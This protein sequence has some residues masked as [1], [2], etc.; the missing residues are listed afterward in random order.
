MATILKR[1]RYS[2]ELIKTEKPAVFSRIQMDLNKRQDFDEWVSASQLRNYMMQDPLL[3]FLNLYGEKCGFIPDDQRPEYIDSFNINKYIMEQGHRFESAVLQSIKTQF[4]NDFLVITEKDHEDATSVEKYAATVAA[5]NQRAAAIIIHGVLHGKT[6]KT[7]GVVDLMIQESFLHKLFPTFPVSVNDRYVVIDIKFTTLKL[8]AKGGYLLNEGSIPAYK[9]QIW[10]YHQLLEEIQ[11]LQY[12]ISEKYTNHF[13]YVLG[14][15]CSLGGKK[16]KTDFANSISTAETTRDAERIEENDMDNAP[17]CFDMLGIIDYS[18]KDAEYATLAQNAIDWLRRLKSIRSTM[19]TNPRKI[20]DNPTHP[21]NPL[22]TGPA[23]MIELYP[24]MSNTMDIPWHYAKKDI[25]KQVSE[26]TCLWNMG[27]KRRNELVA[28]GITQ[29]VDLTVK[30]LAAEFKSV[31]RSNAPNFKYNILKRILQINSADAKNQKIDM[32]NITSESAQRWKVPEL[33]EF[34][35]DFETVSDI[36]DS[37]EN[38]PQAGGTPMIYMIGC[39]Y[40]DPFTHKWIFRNFIANRLQYADEYIIVSHWLNYMTEVCKELN[41]IGISPRIYHWSF[42]ERSFLNSA[43]GR[44]ETLAP[45]I[46]NYVNLAKAV[47]GLNFIDLH[48]IFLDNCI[49]VKGAFNFRLKNI[50]TAMFNHGFIQTNWGNSTVDGIGASIC[51]YRCNDL[52]IEQNTTIRMV[53]IMNEIIQ[54]NEVDCKVLQQVLQYI[55]SNIKE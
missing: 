44:F 6:T 25:A 7:F 20:I 21:W 1:K 2:A 35:V 30:D 37:F 41:F 46:K 9:A 33:V 45:S 51:C 32:S 48:Q 36:N 28:R 40:K 18:E 55:R 12:P 49:V 23:K 39:G 17:G 26:I 3:D 34:F 54:Y 53:T 13:A 8:T 38:I 29:W 15:R 10:V 47:K 14:R 19:E 24:N 50:A 42:A 22:G 4:P 31:Q 11:R 43:L 27:V 52:A 16:E 5:I